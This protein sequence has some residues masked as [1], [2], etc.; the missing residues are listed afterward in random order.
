[1]TKVRAVYK[2]EAQPNSGELSI[3]VDEVL[4]VI[5]ESGMEG[6]ILSTTRMNTTSDEKHEIIV[7]SGP[8]WEPIA[9]PYYCVVDKPK[10]ESKLKG[11][12]SFIAYSVTSS[13]SGIQVFVS[14]RYKHF[15][16]LHEQ[17]SNKYI[18]TSIPPLPE[19]QV[20]GRYEEELIEHRKNI[21]QLWVDKICRH[22]VLSKSDVWIHFLTCT[23]EKSWKSGKRKAEKD[24][25]VG[26]NFLNCVTVPAEPLDVADVQVETFSRCVRSLEDSVRVMYDRVKDLHIRLAGSY[27]TGWQKLAAGFAGLANSFELDRTDYITS[28]LKECAKVYRHIADQHEESSKKDVDPLMDCLYTYRGLLVNMPEI[29]SIHKVFSI[30]SEHEM[31]KVRRKV[32]TVNYA[33]LAEIHFQHQERGQDF[34]KMMSVF[35]EKQAAFYQDISRQLSELSVKFQNS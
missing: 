22:P 27:K 3:S 34:K 7:N 6:Y 11:L 29:I 20:A 4:T 1:M 9:Q 23:D 28:A 32:D 33:V 8:C 21:L 12:K 13:L 24:E 5:K 16:W 2:F 19:K 18:L 10:K 35:L 31:E 30:I 25:Y 26:G 17:L 14:R 15:D